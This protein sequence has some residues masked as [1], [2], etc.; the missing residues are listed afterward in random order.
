MGRWKNFVLVMQCT[1]NPEGKGFDSFDVDTVQLVPFTTRHL[2]PG[3][4][5]R[6]QELRKIDT[7]R[8][9]EVN[10]E[11]DKPAL[12]GFVISQKKGTEQV[13]SYNAVIFERTLREVKFDK[14][15]EKKLRRKQLNLGEEP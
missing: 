15:W 10:D 12:C 4:H 8:M 5:A 2:V 14:H 9:E 6:V 3:L 13:Y 11:R 1:H 7:A